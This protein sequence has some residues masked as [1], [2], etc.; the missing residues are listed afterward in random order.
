M[1]LQ[2]AMV[3]AL[4]LHDSRIE[5]CGMKEKSEV[6]LHFRFLVRDQINY[7]LNGS[8]NLNLQQY[9]FQRLRQMVM[10]N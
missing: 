6:N 10:G 5:F 2:V 4:P 9:L 3:L 8:C 1:R 7:Q